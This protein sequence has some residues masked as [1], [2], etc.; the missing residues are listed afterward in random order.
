[1]VIKDNYNNFLILLF[2]FLTVLL[3]W[4]VSFYYFDNENLLNKLI[5]DIEDYYYF[6]HV[7]NFLE[8]DFSPDYLKNFPSQNSL[9]IPIYSIIFHVV[10]I[11]LFGFV[12][13]IILEFLCLY[14]FLIILVNFFNKF[15]L[16][17][18]IALLSSILF[19]ILPIIFSYISFP[20]FKITTIENLYSFRFPRPL[21]TS[22]Y[23][24]WGLY[25]SIIFYESN[26]INIS[27]YAFIGIVLGLTFVSYYYNFIHLSLIFLF[28][29]IIKI[30]ENK[31]FLKNNYQGILTSILIFVFVIIPFLILINQ[32]EPDYFS[33]I[34][35][36][37]LDL[38]KKIELLT[39]LFKKIFDIKFL[40]LTFLVIISTFI[41]MKLNIKTLKKKIVFLCLLFISGLI[42]PFF[43]ILISPSISEIYH[44]LNW[45]I[46]ISIFVIITNS[47]LILNFYIKKD[48]SKIFL[49]FFIL[50]F[51][52]LFQIHNYHNIKNSDISLRDDF[53][54]LQVLINKNEE[55]LNHIMTFIPRAQVMLMLQNKR[56]FSTI[57][58]SFSSL[59]FDQLE[60][61]F[62]LNLKFIG[63]KKEDFIKILENKKGT[64][65][66]NNEFLRYLSWY[67]YQANSFKTFNETNDF[68]SSE[69]SFISTTSP[70]RTQQ[71]LI[72][73]FEIKRLKNLFNN[74]K[75]NKD[76][77][78]PD[79]IILKNN[80]LISRYA[81]LDDKNYCEIK[82][83]QTLKIYLNKKIISCD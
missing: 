7:I 51:L 3:K 38:A 42:S 12:S 30:F 39:Y 13:F 29:F 77:D 44:F 1:M 56:K 66:Y 60:K 73:K 34:G 10:F 76:F 63:I 27:K 19:F 70:T 80:S 68:S 45:A 82:G 59:N 11:K 23:F 2:S 52:F 25:L 41:L 21:I 24:F 47:I 67:R 50:F 28:I 61:S 15:N 48:I 22:L 43:F 81:N 65:R 35:V 74:F 8:F 54:K 71:I 72:P 78:N 5:F 79:L 40:F 55:K 58:S 31:N 20:N 62:I 33:M 57:E 16:N 32:S 64:W 69:L 49:Y 18:N 6:P 26:K 36:I 53:Y 46:I 17:P 14:L 37:S 75:A 83:Y 9:P 4:L